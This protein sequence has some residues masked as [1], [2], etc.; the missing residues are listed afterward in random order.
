MQRRLQDKVLFGSDYPG[1]SPGQCADE[2]QMEGFKPGII[3]KL[4]YE[5]ATRILNLEAAIAHATKAGEA[6]VP[7]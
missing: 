6:S 7:A 2:W 5:N 3:E 4:F 1:W